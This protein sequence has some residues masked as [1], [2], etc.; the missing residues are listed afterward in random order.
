MRNRFDTLV[1]AWGVCLFLTTVLEAT[2][3]QDDPRRVLNQVGLQAGSLDSAQVSDEASARPVGLMVDTLLAYHPDA[4]KNQLTPALATVWTLSSDGLTYRFTLRPDACYQDDPCFATGSGR[5]ITAQDFIFAWKRVVD[6][7]V[8]SPGSWLFLDTIKGMR[9][10]NQASKKPTPTDYNKPVSGLR[11]IDDYTLEVTLT[12]PSRQFLW[13]LTMAYSAP[14]PQEAVDYYGSLTEHPISSGPYELKSWHRSYKRV[15]VRNPNWYGWRS[16]DFDGAEVPFETINQLII[17]DPSTQWLALLK[18]E[19]DLLTQMDRNSFEI[20]IDSSLGKNRLLDEHNIA[21]HSIPTLNVYYILLNSKDPIMQNKKL[22]Q[23]LNCAFDRKRW[24]DFFQGRVK[25]LN[26]P[27]P[28]HLPGALI[29]PHPYTYNLTRAKQLLIEAGY[30]NGIDPQT[31]RRLQL[32]LDLGN[33]TQSTR[34][35]S[36]LLASFYAEV[37][38]DLQLSYNQWPAFLA[39]VSSAKAQMAL[40][41][42][43][44]DYPDV[45]NFLQMFHSRNLSPGPNRSN[46]VNPV[47]DALYEQA[48]ATKSSADAHDIWLKLQRIVVK[49]C[50]WVFLHYGIDFSLANRRLINYQIHNFPYG[51]ERYW[52]VRVK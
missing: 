22:R 13:F 30:P 10:F 8:A 29:A 34:E 31:G 27:T 12:Q 2:P 35:S 28:P 40:M 7:K 52:R 45:E 42:W 38:I 24:L 44:G 20:V 4:S 21:L 14:V 41:A 32:T 23:A 37:G 33:T 43:A 5:T 17:K 47:V 46:Y 48:I 26:G 6:S 16:V 3:H 9:D 15:F 1:V 49:D 36:E 19:V 11:A 25:E 51:M 18:G 39:K 50:P